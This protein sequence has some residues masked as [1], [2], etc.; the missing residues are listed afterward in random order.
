MRGMRFFKLEQLSLVC[1]I[2]L[3]VCIV[4]Y[5][6]A[7]DVCTQNLES[8]QEK[9]NNGS[10]YSVEPLL[11]ECLKSGFTKQERI[12]A[13]ELLA[14]TKLFL[15]DLEGANSIYLK[16]LNIDPEHQ[17]NSLIDPPDL[18]FLHESFRTRP[19][20]YWTI[21]AGT[22]YSNAS[23]IHD[24]STFNLSSSDKS[25]SAGFGFEVGGG[26][27]TNIWKKL[28]IEM[29]FLFAQKNH[30]YLENA[31]ND[32]PPEDNAAY[33]ISYTETQNW[34]SLPL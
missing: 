26:I 16:L 5:T 8:A 15:D 33:S 28:S 21:F 31:L 25:S 30:S 23:A 34:I 20:F 14:I 12:E 3:N 32:F 17:V 24:Y 10:F 19:L 29:D 11:L 1:L 2:L 13:L 6:N 7:Q 4:K 22:N 18:V 27:E 9:F